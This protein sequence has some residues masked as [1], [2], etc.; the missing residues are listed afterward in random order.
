M[1]RVASLKEIR[2]G[3]GKALTVQ[4]RE[5]AIFRIG[6]EVFAFENLC[7]HQHVPVLAEGSL[8]GTVLT[9]PMHGWRFD[10][11]DGS[12][13]HASGRLKTFAVE[14]RGDDVYIDIDEEADERW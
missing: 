6:D 3:K 2:I 11:T 13:V 1:L 4:G 14:L 12:C 9:C 8:E 5:V 10:I 7:P